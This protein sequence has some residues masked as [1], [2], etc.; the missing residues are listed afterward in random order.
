MIPNSAWKDY[1]SN[2]NYA[3]DALGE[4]EEKAQQQQAATNTKS[5]RSQSGQSQ[6]TTLPMSH[7]PSKSPQYYDNS[8]MVTST[9]ASPARNGRSSYQQNGGGLV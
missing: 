3:F 2:T 8:M 4:T 5:R 1:S 7:S 6:Q 9:G